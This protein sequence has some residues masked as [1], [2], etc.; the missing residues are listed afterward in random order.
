MA[1]VPA[2]LAAVWPRVLEQLLGE[3]RVQGVEAKDEHWIRRCQ[4]LALVA[5]TA[6][7]A[8]PNE[9]AKGVLEGR[10]AP[11]VSE[12]LSRECGRP[13]RI[14]ITVDDSA[15]EPP[16]PPAPP[17]PRTQPRYE[18]PELPS[19]QY[20][21]QYEGY[22]R[23]RAD[24]SRPPRGEQR[25]GTQG[26]HAPRPD[27]LP[28]ARPAYPSEYQRPEPGAWPR[29][30]QD[31]YGWQ[32]QRLGF[33][34]RD[35]Y[36]SPSQEPYSQEPYKPES[37]QQESYQQDSYGPPSQDY[38]PQPMERSSYDG[39]RSDYDQ[40]PEYDKRPDYDKPRSDYDQR[41]T[42]RDLPDP[43]P[44]SGHVHR[45]GPVGS[46]LPTT[47]APGPLAAQPAPAT[48]PGEPTARLNPKYLF[49]TFV[50]GASNRFAHAAAVAVAEAPAKA[51]NPLFI[52]GES[53]LGKTH[54]LHAIG[55]Y[56]RSLYPGTRVRYVSS[57]EFT[58]EF[59]NSIRDGKGD[60]FRKRYREMDILLVDDIQFLADKESTQ[61]EFFHTFNTLHNANKQI[62]L[63]SDRPPKQ[64]VT[65]EDRLRN[66]FEWGLITDVQ[67]PEL[68]TRIAILRKKAVQEQLNAPPEVLEFIA[69]RIS[70]NIRE[71][72]GALIRVTAFASLNRQPVDLGLTEIVLKDL[73]PG[74]EDSAPEITSTAIM[75]ATADYFGL[76]VEDLCGTSRGRALVTARQ[77]AMYLCRE[78][79]DLSL[80][81]IGALFGGRDH[82][83]VMHADR[84]IRNLM[85]ERRSIYNQ[86]TELTNRIKNG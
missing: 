74:G 20:D 38:R 68:E 62:V 82:T 69:S 28:T 25:P 84:K 81:K 22:G 32:Q 45:G 71:L 67:P 21:N 27:Q 53:G 65:L 66:R 8:V 40:R 11:A 70:R 50:I 73:I 12:T 35:P 51:Y 39:P 18:E 4:P 57:E 33:P 34:E 23:H 6:L 42:R 10:L 14:A 75:S 44:G 61:E 2:D 5:D 48:G 80:P 7:L 1:D 31:D 55:H 17:A 52:Y 3:G 58:N 15:G 9:F 64:L 76:T 54:L 49:D 77:I 16:A 79:T 86:V 19:G 29:P 41:D 46:N 85:A 47:G 72:E 60:S 83:T 24:D 13:I 78:L 36:A 37:Y 63:S 59:I 56:A 26:D 43:P 30:A